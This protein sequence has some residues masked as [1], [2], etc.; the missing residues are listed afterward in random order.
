[1]N[2]TFI[3]NDK[4]KRISIAALYWVTDWNHRIIW[5]DSLYKEITT[6]LGVGIT[7]GIYEVH[8]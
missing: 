4:K 5:Y 2:S 7:D 3:R 8:R 6:G 1:M